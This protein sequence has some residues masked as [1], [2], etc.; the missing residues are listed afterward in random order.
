MEL[1]SQS[2]EQHIFLLS[3]ILVRLLI[4][5]HEQSGCERAVLGA[6]FIGKILPSLQWQDDTKVRALSKM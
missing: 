4:D 2:E 5:H 1:Q 6:Q 3:I